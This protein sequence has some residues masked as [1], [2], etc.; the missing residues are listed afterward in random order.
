MVQLGPTLRFMDS[1][2]VE[3]QS[4][5]CFA[6]IS[7]I[8]Y[9]CKMEKLEPQFIYRG[10]INGKADK[11]TALPTFS[12]TLTLSQQRGAHC[13]HMEVKGAVLK[14]I[15]KITTKYLTCLK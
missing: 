1:E 7:E 3:N 13:F 12:D 8:S 2:I 15:S 14:A 9:H 11:A 4:L 5:L 10:V 6:V